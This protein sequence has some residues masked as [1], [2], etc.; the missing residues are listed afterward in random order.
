MIGHKLGREKVGP[1][2]AHQ[3]GDSLP[4]R[5]A[6]DLVAFSERY[7]Q[8]DG[9]GFIALFLELME[10]MPNHQPRSSRKTYW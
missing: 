7:L 5:G 2:L 8:I 9:L 4:N 10:C 1:E 6:T 3:L